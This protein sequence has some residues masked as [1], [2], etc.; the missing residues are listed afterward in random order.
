MIRSPQVINLLVLTR[1][2]KMIIKYHFIQ[3]FHPL[4]FL[5]F[6]QF[7]KHAV[8]NLHHWGTKPDARKRHHF[9]KLTP[10]DQ[11]FMTLV[12]LWLDLKF[13]DLLFRFNISLDW[14]QGILILRYICFL[15]HH[16]KETDWMPSTEQVEG[17]LP[18]AFGEKYPSTYCSI[19]G[20]EIFMEMPSDLHM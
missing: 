11:Q 15:Y 7:P 2:N 6:Y 14:F 12:K 20:S 18:S 4:L 19:D 5:E 10:M 9:T 1:L 16:L 8:D 3:D 17:V 13:V